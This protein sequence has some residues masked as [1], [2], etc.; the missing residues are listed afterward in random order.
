M[1]YVKNFVKKYLFFVYF[2]LICNIT[3]A[4]INYENNIKKL[5][6][7][8]FKDKNIYPNDL[9]TKQELN[10]ENNKEKAIKKD[11]IKLKRLK[12]TKKIQ[13]SKYKYD[14]FSKETFG[15]TVMAI[16]GFGFLPLGQIYNGDYKT[17][18]TFGLIN[19]ANIV[20]IP[21][22]PNSRRSSEGYSTN[23]VVFLGIWQFTWIAE[24]LQA[25][26]SASMK[27]NDS[28]I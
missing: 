25:F 15:A 23:S 24:I 9:Q 6:T 11:N 22:W 12:E 16:C 7:P 4:Q 19:I 8:R 3:K 27:V 14:F 1:Y 5:D 20:L 13:K 2:S 26:I 21:V 18:L 17:A 28:S 10:Q